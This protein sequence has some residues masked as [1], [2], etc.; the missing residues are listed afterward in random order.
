MPT[1]IYA[2]QTKPIAGS[3]TSTLKRKPKAQPIKSIERFSSM[4][5]APKIEVATMV[6][7]D[8][9]TRLSSHA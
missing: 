7:N 1:V 9:L 3:R 2:T 6:L 5:A 4:V 8:Q